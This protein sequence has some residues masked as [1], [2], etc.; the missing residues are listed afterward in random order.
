MEKQYDI[1]KDMEKRTGG[2]LYLGVVGPVRSGKSTFI[3][4]FM[5][6]LV[7]PGVKDGFMKDRIRDEL[8]QSAEGKTIMTTEPKFVPKEAVPITLG[9]GSS[10]QIRLID[11]VGYLIDGVSGHM[12]DDK[13][14]M[15]KTPWSERPMTFSKAAEI[16]T[17]KV[18]C[19]HSNVGIVMTTDASFGELERN[20]Y[21]PAEE[22]VVSEL[23]EQGK[24]FIILLNSSHPRSQE[25]KALAVS[26]EEKYGASVMPLSCE[27]LKEE[28]VLHI[29]ERILYEFPVAAFYIYLPK[30]MEMLENAHPMKQAA[31]VLAKALGESCFYMRDLGK[32]PAIFDACK[33]ETGE[34]PG[35]VLVKNGMKELRMRDRDLSNGIVTL[36]LVMEDWCYYHVLSSLTGMKI[37]N[38]YHLIQSLKEMAGKRQE[39][40]KVGAALAAVSAAGYGIVTPGKEEIVLGEPEVMKSGSKYGV[41]IQ[42]KAPSIHFIKTDIMT[43]I[44]P[45]VGSEEQ[46]ED[47]IRFIKESG[48]SEAGIWQTNIFGKTIEQIVEDGIRVKVEKLSETTRGRMIDTLEKITNDANRGVICIIL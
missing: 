45:I 22:R 44:A 25:T 32:I 40:E 37:D 12:E 42:A 11:C 14:R 6:L 8:P 28:D 26:L 4:R 43:E 3:K 35:A 47:L 34:N 21:I 27:Q 24:P 48:A 19:D 38:E 30:W 13:E 17:K 10:L 46:A 7:L 29:L 33:G 2:E 39:Y 5:E 1:Y 20:Q 9:D 36:E 16:G 41:K 18:I 31:I 23:K 15:V